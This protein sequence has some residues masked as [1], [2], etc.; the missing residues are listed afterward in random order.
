M[1]II[2][3]DTLSSA[4]DRLAQDTLTKIQTVLKKISQSWGGV[5]HMSFKPPMP[6]GGAIYL[7][8]YSY[9][10][11]YGSGEPDVSYMSP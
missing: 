6:G 5:P 4:T 10:F 7:Y 8:V 9:S 1:F 11:V 3:A 2:S